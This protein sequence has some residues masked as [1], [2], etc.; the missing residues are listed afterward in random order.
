[1]SRNNKGVNPIFPT[2]GSEFSISGKFTIPYSLFDNVNYANLQNE[3]AYRL[4]NDTGAVIKGANGADIAPGA[5][6]GLTEI[7]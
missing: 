7:G 6:I 4:T 3:E 1:L 2:Y 5:Y